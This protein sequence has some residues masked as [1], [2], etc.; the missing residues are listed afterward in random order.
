MIITLLAFFGGALTILSPCILP[1]L[2]FVFARTDRSF[3]RNTAMLVGMAVTFAA[4]GTLAAVGGAWAVRVNDYGRY[5][6]MIL[7]ALTG[8][9]L[10]SETLADRMTRPIVGL[11]NRLVL[12]RSPEDEGGVLGSLVLG[13][14]TGFSGRRA[15][16]RSWV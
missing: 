11:G 12:A 5:I 16:V 14:A 6:S 15:Q 1:V 10:L 4:L 8:L 9:A 13:I 7:L 2:P 3:L